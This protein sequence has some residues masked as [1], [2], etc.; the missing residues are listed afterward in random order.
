MTMH[1][2][3]TVE[4][5]LASTGPRG[6]IAAIRSLLGRVPLAVHQLLFRLAI[7]GV[8]FRAGLQK[9][10]GW[11]TTLALFSDEYKLPGVPPEIAATM[12]TCFELGCSTLL[13]LGLAGRL[14]TPLLG[15]IVTIQLFVY[16]QAR[17]EHLV[18]GSIL[19]FLLTR[20]PG[21]ISLDRVIGIEPKNGA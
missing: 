10:R 20:G 15:M 12:A 19:V 17:P 13:I 8:F 3:S 14:A 18:W 5:M 9:A 7:A 2:A 16:P 21:A 4:P 1:V 11:E 6:R